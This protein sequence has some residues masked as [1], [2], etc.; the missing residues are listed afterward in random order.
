M[1]VAKCLAFSCM[2]VSS[3]AFSQSSVNALVIDAYDGDTL[4]VD[5]AIWPDLAWSGSVRVRHVDTPE[6]RG[7][8]IQERLLAIAARDY[9]RDLLIDETVILTEIENDLYGGRILAHVALENGESL[10]DRLIDNGLGRPYD[11]GRRQGWCASS[12]L[13]ESGLPDTPSASANDT[14]S[15]DVAA[16]HPLY[17]YDDNGNGRISCAEAREHG[18]APVYAGD[19]AYPYMTDGDGDGVVCE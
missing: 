17:L 4:T 3:A 9:V 15:P 5:A 1:K 19:P 13:G 14:L 18:I 11:G 2:V 7:D 10:A 16:D 8:C 12:G 6:I